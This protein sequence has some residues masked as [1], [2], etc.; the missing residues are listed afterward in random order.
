VVDLAAQFEADRYCVVRS[1]I[2]ESAL[3][4]V[5]EYMRASV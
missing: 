3:A 5:R 2:D 1:L 4:V